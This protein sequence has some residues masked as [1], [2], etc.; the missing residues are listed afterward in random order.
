MV[1]SNLNFCSACCDWSIQFQIFVCLTVGDPGVT[2]C[3]SPRGSVCFRGA[4]R[5]PGAGAVRCTAAAP[6]C[7]SLRVP[8]A[9]PWRHRGAARSGGAVRSGYRALHRGGTAVPRAPGAVRSGCREPGAGAVRSGCRS[10][11]RCRAPGAGAVRSTW[12]APRCRALRPA[13]FNGFWNSNSQF[14]G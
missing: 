11:P 13:I 4:A 3:Q 2:G 10:L 8:C 9:P 1:H 12:A 14:R 7:R 6:G 5:F